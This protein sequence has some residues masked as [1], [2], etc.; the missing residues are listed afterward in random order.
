MAAAAGG[1]DAGHRPWWESEISDRPL[2]EVVGPPPAISSPTQA[3]S[4]PAPTTT[5]GTESETVVVITDN[6]PRTV[7]PAAAATGPGLTSRG[8]FLFM[9]APALIGCLIGFVVQGATAIPAMAGYG[10]IVGSLVAALRVAPRLNWFPVWLPPLAMLTVIA[11]AGQ[12]TLI[13]ARPTLA[14]EVSMIMVNLAATAPAQI[15][16]MAVVAAVIGLRRRRTR[17]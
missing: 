16:A 7:I 2:P 15:I 1:S 10:L 5:P 14:R 17:R 11:V 13:G 3:E 9:A 4:A 6:Q 8:A 12:I